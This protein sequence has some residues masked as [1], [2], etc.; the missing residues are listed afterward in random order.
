MQ[1]Y[2]REISCPVGDRLIRK[3]QGF[4]SRVFPNVEALLLP[5]LVIVAGKALA[6]PSVR[7]QLPVATDVATVGRVSADRAIEASS[8]HCTLGGVYVADRVGTLAE[9]R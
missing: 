2:S 1:R 8:I 4:I 7:F 5:K 3:Y 6:E 9:D